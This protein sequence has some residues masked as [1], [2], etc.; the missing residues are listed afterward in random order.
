MIELLA[1]FA[2]VAAMFVVVLIVGATALVAGNAP[3]G[4]TRPAGLALTAA[5]LTWGSLA[6]V[7]VAPLPIRWAQSISLSMWVLLSI[8]SAIVFWFCR[9][10]APEEPPAAPPPPTYPRIN[11]Q[12]KPSSTTT[13]DADLL[14]RTYRKKGA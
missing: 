2:Y 5:L 8:L 6:Y 10:I 1:P 11:G 7:I 9:P 4:S 3:D 12:F 13:I 14:R